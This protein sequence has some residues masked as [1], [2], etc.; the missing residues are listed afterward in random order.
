MNFENFKF[1]KLSPAKES[2]LYVGG[3]KLCSWY[4]SSINPL[5]YLKDVVRTVN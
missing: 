4:P 5:H 1:V 2:A 3:D